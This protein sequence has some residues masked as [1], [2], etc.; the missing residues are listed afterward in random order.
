MFDFKLF[1]PAVLHVERDEA[2]I[3]NSDGF[4]KY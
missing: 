1:F 4:Q 3:D 2:L